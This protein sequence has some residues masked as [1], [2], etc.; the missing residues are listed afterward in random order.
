MLLF[1]RD[2]L[3]T[4][5]RKVRLR[6]VI[7]VAIWIF[8]LLTGL[9]LLS[10]WAESF[11]SN[12]Q[13]QSIVSLSWSGY[14]IA[15]SI[16]QP[17]PEVSQIIASWIVPNVKI[18]A[19][20]SYSSAWIGIGGQFDKTLIQVGTEHN[21]INGNYIYSAWYEMLPNLAVQ[22]NAIQ[23]S[24]GDKI[25]A[26]IT[27]I[28]SNTNVWNIQISDATTSQAFNQNFSYNSTRLSGEWMVER[29]TVN[30]QISA[31]ADFDTVT[32]TDCSLKLNNADGPIGNFSYSQIRMA[33]NAGTQLTNISPVSGDG[34]SFS[35]SYLASS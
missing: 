1:L 13:I 29:P 28:N 33:N 14:L 35:V 18:S 11:R 3:L 34:S 19:G 6:T 9:L 26:A 7:L 30:N 17:Q 2:V 32:F 24:P 10:L 31:L 27:L 25:T 8:L 23:V 22:L 16:D 4:E 21:F 5:R 15:S 20:D 12:P